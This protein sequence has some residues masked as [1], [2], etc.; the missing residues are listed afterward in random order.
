MGKVDSGGI[1]EYE[2]DEKKIVVFEVVSGIPNNYESG[3]S[4]DYA[5]QLNYNMEN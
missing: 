5:E 2:T 4:D 1:Q 3:E